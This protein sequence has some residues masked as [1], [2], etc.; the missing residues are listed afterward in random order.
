MF[1]QKEIKAY[2]NIKA[3]DSLKDSIMADYD[4]DYTPKRVLPFGRLLTYASAA[5]C[6]IFI[7]TF[8]VFTLKSQT[9]FTASVNGAPLSSELML[10]SD[11]QPVPMTADVRVLSTINV[12]IKLDIHRNTEIT[13]D[14]GIIQ[15]MDPKGGEVIYSDTTFN[16]DTDILVCWEII[17]DSDTAAYTM[18]IS[19]S[20]GIHVITLAFDDTVDAWTLCCKKTD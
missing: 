9:A 20:K 8:S 7:I 10:L 1:S 4:L 15:V 12:P 17:P 18:T 14:N 5:V 13:A 11:D 2:R 6:V 16:T 19:D 3:P